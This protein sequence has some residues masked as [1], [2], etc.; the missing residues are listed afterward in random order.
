MEP[1]EILDTARQSGEP[2]EGWTVVPLNRDTV[3]RSILG[4]ALSAL[5]GFVLLGLLIAFVYDIFTIL[6]VPTLFMLLFGFLGAGSLYLVVKKAR[7]LLDADRHLIVFT[8]DRYV[9]QV[10]GKTIDVPL[11]EITHIT[12]RGV[13]G[14]TQASKLSDQDVTVA[15]FN[16]QQFF[17]GRQ[18]HRQRRTPDSLAFVDE[19]DGS[20]VVVADDNSYTDLAVLDELLH[21]YTEGA[22]RVRS[23]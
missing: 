1:N 20:V 3:R 16:M 13:F 12:L 14:G 19:R 22:R 2:P 18:L 6:S 7:M 5:L 15:A 17:G 8:P 4:W 21:V 23:H 9:Q 11:N 10:G